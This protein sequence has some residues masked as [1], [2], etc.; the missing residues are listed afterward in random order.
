MTICVPTIGRLATLSSTLASVQEQS[1]ANCE[2]LILDNA[3]PPA[4]RAILDQYCKTDRRARLLSSTTR[5]S[6]FDNFQRGVDAAQGRYL[7]FF[8]DDDV[9]AVD[10]VTQHVRLLE[11][12]PAAAFAGANCTVIDGA[13]RLVSDR[14]LIRRTE[15]WPGWR[16]IREVYTLGNNVFPMQSVMLRR[17]LLGPK[18]FDPSRGVHFSDYLLLM[19]LAESHDV[20]LIDARLLQLRTHDDQASRGLPA[21]E[22]L[23]LRTRLF[24]QYANELTARWPA[25][26]AEILKLR[27][28]VS[29]A[30]RSAAIWMWLTA[31]DEEQAGDARAALKGPG[32]DG[33]LG[34]GMHFADRIGISRVIRNGGARRRIRSVAYSLIGRSR[35]G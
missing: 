18:T 35:H 13:G 10:F 8:H 17:E 4:A 29:P 23:L 24:E 19:R 11:S 5:L 31:T 25:R 30:R 3:T 6:M 15:V 9:Y 27:Q 14:G 12:H 1:H 2:V 28:R 20:G 26:A 32:L 21:S 22:A 16:Y 33:W 34:R 7:A